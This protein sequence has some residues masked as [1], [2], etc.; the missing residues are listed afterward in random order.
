MHTCRTEL[1]RA[2]ATGL[3]AAA[4]LVMLAGTAG[5]QFTTPGIGVHWTMDDL[6]AQSGGVVT[7]TAP[8][9]ELHDAVTVAATDT[10]TVGPGERLTFIDGAG[11]FGLTINGCL[12]AVG[13]PADSV[14]FTADPA[15][16]GSWAGLEFQDP[17]GGSGF[18]L[19]YCVL[20]YAHTAV[21]VDD[22][23]LLIEHSALRRNDYKVIGF[24]N[25]AGEVRD[26][27]IRHN[28]QNTVTMTNNSSPLFEDCL[29][30]DNNRVNEN[31]YPYF[32]I[33]F[34][35]VNSPTIRG[36]TIHGSGHESSGGIAVWNACAGL[37]EGNTIEGCGYGIWCYQFDANPTI[38]DNVIVDNNI[39]PDLLNWNFG[40]AC[41]GDNA[42]LIIGNRI[43]GH[44][45]G[46]ALINGAQPNL[47]DLINDFP[48]DDGMN[49]FLGNAFGGPQYE[50]YNNTVNDIMAQNNWWGTADPMEIEDRIVHQVDD[51]A[52]GLVNFVP[53]LET[54]AVGD[55]PPAGTALLAAATAYPNPFNPRVTVAFAL[56]RDAVVTLRIHDAGGRLVRELGGAPFPAGAHALVW[57]GAD[58]AGR[59]VASGTYVYRITA[60]GGAAADQTAAGK[61]T[62]VR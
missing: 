14:T 60:A 59:A 55:G 37:F 25:A 38:K 46:V 9:Y 27:V 62:L 49:Q 57:D 29:F 36:N 31:L 47:G 40:I 6:V 50:L 20:E 1:G 32:N 48:G 24:D 2:P 18:R 39:H 26:C 54:T 7:G 35:G 19:D 23:D 52:L 43:S 28:E 5:A 41:N 56:R 61:L 13:A 45:Y 51:A 10:L 15:T 53:Y 44:V 34:L 4:L 8:A 16:P 22:A 30:E 33:G 17:V 21:D 42:P 11:S 58:D 3:L 12:L